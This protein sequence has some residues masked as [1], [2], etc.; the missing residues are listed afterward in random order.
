MPGQERCSVVNYTGSVYW[1]RVS[2]SADAFTVLSNT[3][4]NP[5]KIVV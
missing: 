5:R 1:L 2:G 3:A 4:V